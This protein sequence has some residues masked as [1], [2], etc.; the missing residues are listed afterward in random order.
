MMTNEKLKEALD[1]GFKNESEYYKY[2]VALKRELR[3]NGVVFDKEGST[4][5]LIQLK[6][7]I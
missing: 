6:E 7:L 3:K 2:R 5:A 4:T 1:L